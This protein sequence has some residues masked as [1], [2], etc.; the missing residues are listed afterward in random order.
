MKRFLSILFAILFISSVFAVSASAYTIRLS[1]FF[2]PQKTEENADADSNETGNRP[3]KEEGGDHVVYTSS[4]QLSPEGKKAYNELLSAIQAQKPTAELDVVSPEERNHFDGILRQEH[5]ELNYVGTIP[6]GTMHTGADGKEWEEVRINYFNITEDI[7]NVIQDF[8]AGAPVHGTDYEKELYVHDKLVEE[9]YF[10]NI[11]YT[12]DNIG[13]ILQDTLV[14]H[15]TS[16]L[17]YAY[18]MRALLNQ[19]GVSCDIV[20]GTFTKDGKTESRAWNRVTLNGKPYLVDAFQDDPY[21]RMHSMSHR[22]FNLT[23]KEMDRDHK[24]NDP[25]QEKN[26]THTEQNYF[27]K[28]GLMFSSVPA[29]ETRLKTLLRDQREAEVRLNS[30]S[31]ARQV[32]SDLAAGQSYGSE[33]DPTNGVVSAYR[34]N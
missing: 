10:S 31:L 7:Q 21:G 15:A 3:W 1:D 25:E 13:N 8:L 30:E 19:L 22:Y 28:N 24:P 6:G 4:S 18:A 33:T 34:N 9:T 16:S 20:Q 12:K 11:T 2:R 23:Q 29:A 27:R 14:Q 26:C 17:G 32:I 5:P